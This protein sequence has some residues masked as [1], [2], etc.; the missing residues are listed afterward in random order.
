MNLN[1]LEIVVAAGSVVS[2]IGAAVSA[3]YALIA[4]RL[5]KGNISYQFYTRY[6]DEK[7]HKALQKVGAFKK[8]YTEK[9]REEF[10]NI[11]YA[12]YLNKEGW[13][14]ELEDARRTVK[15]FY[16]DVATLHQDGCINDATA[17]KICSAGG[18]VLFTECI[19]P[20]EKK[21]NPHQFY[22]EYY[23]IPLIAEKLKKERDVFKN[24]KAG[25]KK[26]KFK[27]KG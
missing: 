13:A 5:T 3:Y 27:Y 10:I 20:M 24:K 15:Y 17:E 18:I 6:C 26:P 25:D 9:H 1:L 19:L 23:P 2:C 11:W 14:L 7:M 16:R 22:D 12:A 4:G 21:V 8:E